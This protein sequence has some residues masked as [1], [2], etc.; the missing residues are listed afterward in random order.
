MIRAISIVGT[1]TAGHVN[2]LGR[3]IELE[4]GIVAAL[5]QP[6]PIIS[7]DNLNNVLLRSPALCTALTENPARLRPLGSSEN[8]EINTRALITLNGNGLRIGEDLV[9]RV[10]IAELDANVENPELR[11]FPGDFLADIAEARP[12]LLAGVLTI[13]R[14]GRLHRNQ[15]QRGLPLGSYSQWA[16]WIRDVLITLGC[17]DPVERV[18][19]AKANDAGRL[20]TLGIF[21]AWWEQFGTDV[22]TAKDAQENEKVRAAIEDGELLSRQKVAAKLSSLIG[23]RLGGYVMESPNK[24]EKEQPGSKK[25]FAPYT[26]RLLLT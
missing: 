9:R 26:Y 24:A 18:E 21:E 8:R 19:T 15:L 16:D 2:S 17:R 14:W 3:G 23:V 22:K 6:D 20:Y 5:L 7:L 10:V 4:K 12:R 25:K 13:W 1:G 11:D